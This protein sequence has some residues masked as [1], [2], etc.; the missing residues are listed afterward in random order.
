MYLE[1]EPHTS[2]R[3]IFRS[4]LRGDPGGPLQ[5][6]ARESMWDHAYSLP[7]MTRK[8]PVPPKARSRQAGKPAHIGEPWLPC[9]Q[10]F[11]SFWGGVFR[12]PRLDDRQLAVCAALEI[13]PPHTRTSAATKS[14]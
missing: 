2:S 6:G 10:P 3:S 14:S 7:E 9:R 8:M 5:K 12:L 1:G 13:R 11:R 4:F